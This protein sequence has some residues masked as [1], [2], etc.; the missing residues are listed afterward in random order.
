MQ[1]AAP[2]A[3]T[4]PAITVFP[5]VVSH[6]PPPAALRPARG[7]FLRR[8]PSPA[9]ATDDGPFAHQRFLQLHIDAV[10]LLC[11][12]EEGGIAR[13][14][15]A[16]DAQCASS[17]CCVESVLPAFCS[18]TGL[19]SLIAAVPETAVRRPSSICLC[20]NLLSSSLRGGAYDPELLAG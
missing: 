18:L 6:A 11:E 9:S 17:C 16:I 7:H 5:F 3:S 2:L 19:V 8:R 1:F 4:Y 10:I 13:S 15:E 14:E 20:S 12:E